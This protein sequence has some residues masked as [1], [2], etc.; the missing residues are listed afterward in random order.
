MLLSLFNLLMRWLFFVAI[1]WP[2]RA[3]AILNTDLTLEAK[4]SARVYWS[5]PDFVILIPED[6]EPEQCKSDFLVQYFK[7]EKDF[8]NFSL[9]YFHK[10]INIL[11]N[12]S[13]YLSQDFQKKSIYNKKWNSNNLGLEHLSQYSEVVY[14][15]TDNLDI[16]FEDLVTCWN[17]RPRY[18]SSL[19]KLVE[20]LRTQDALVAEIVSYF[21]DNINEILE[22]IESGF[23][24]DKDKKQIINKLNKLLAVSKEMEQMLLANYKVLSNQLEYI[25]QVY[26]GI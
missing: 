7:A 5:K 4:E 16:F 24:L 20:S 25:H 13:Q 22:S 12:F 2:V 21:F 26:W 8:M 23:L 14:G 17:L 18:F 11:Q 15:A 9:V 3:E 10:H 1:I 19:K 6:L